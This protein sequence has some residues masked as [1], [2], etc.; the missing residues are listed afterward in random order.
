MAVVYPST[1]KEFGID[2]GRAAPY[3]NYMAASLQVKDH[4]LG[5]LAMSALLIGVHIRAP[6][7]WKLPC[8]GKSHRRACL[9]AVQ[10][11]KNKRRTHC[12]NSN[13]QAVL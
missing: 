2:Q 10:G 5:F 7:S 8:A 9:I 4:C 3:E 12:S 6:D 13:D 11:P 1:L